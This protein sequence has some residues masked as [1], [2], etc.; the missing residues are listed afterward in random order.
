VARITDLW[1]ADD[2]VRGKVEEVDGYEGALKA[3]DYLSPEV[4]W[5]WTHPQ[6]G[7]EYK[8]VLF[9]AAA[10]NYPFF[11]GQMALHGE[12]GRGRDSGGRVRETGDTRVFRGSGADLRP[13]ERGLG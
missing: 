4:R 10:T 2:G 12:Q 6:T 7:Q 1:L 3:F 5:T 11:L 13:A 8:N 9:G